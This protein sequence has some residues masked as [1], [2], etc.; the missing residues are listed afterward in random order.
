M[1]SSFLLSDL[2]TDNHDV[3]VK[4]LLH[5]FEAERVK[6]WIPSVVEKER[7]RVMARAKEVVQSLSAVGNLS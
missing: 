4:K 6:R 5:R 1:I 7:T 2:T 3:Y